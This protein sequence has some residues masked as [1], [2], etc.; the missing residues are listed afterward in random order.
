MGSS[1]TS[2]P[3]GS[4]E[5]IGK[6]ARIRLVYTSDPYT[7]LKSGDTGTVQDVC[8]LP[9]SVGGDIQIWVSWDKGGSQFAL[10]QDK[11]LYEYWWPILQR[12]EG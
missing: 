10:L 6:G 8:K 11:D 4:E 9:D 2:T 5:A 7:D 12:G 1:N 3:A